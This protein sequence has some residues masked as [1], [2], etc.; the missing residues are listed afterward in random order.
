MR[1]LLQRVGTM[2]VL[3]APDSYDS[4]TTGIGDGHIQING[5]KG[6]LFAILVGDIAE[7]GTLDFAAVYSST[8]SAT[9][10]DYAELAG[11]T[12][13]VLSLDSDST[14]NTLYLIDV[15]LG[16]KSVVAAGGMAMTATMNGAAGE[17]SVLAIPY[18]GNLVLPISQTNTPTET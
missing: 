2:T 3:W 11:A 13:A 10:S 12:D 7:G 1:D 8:N 18:G 4:D 16:D 14:A 9:A 15:F 5:Y 17:F 6:I